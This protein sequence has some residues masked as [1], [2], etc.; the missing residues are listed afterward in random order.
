MSKIGVF[1][2]I[3]LFIMMIFFPFLVSNEKSN[4]VDLSTK[5]TITG[6]KYRI[7]YVDDKGIVT[8]D[9]AK[10]Y[11]TMIQIRDTDGNAVEEYYYNTKEKPVKCSSGYYGIHRIYQDGIC[12]EYTFVDQEGNPMEGKSRYSTVKQ[13]YNNKNQ[14]VE[15]YYPKLF[16]KANL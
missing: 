5:E 11:S 16:M 3:C 1:I 8:I 7:D 15:V 10:G 12:V 14:I 6:N 2:T 4:N 9:P 13:I